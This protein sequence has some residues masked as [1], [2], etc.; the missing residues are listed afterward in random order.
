MKTLIDFEG[1]LFSIGSIQIIEKTMSW[2]EKEECMMY[3]ILINNQNLYKENTIPIPTFKF[4]YYQE[5][6]RDK[7]FQQLYDLLAEFEHIEI[8]VT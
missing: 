4:E 5:E 7:K 3:N 8:L 2:N 6:F 1:K